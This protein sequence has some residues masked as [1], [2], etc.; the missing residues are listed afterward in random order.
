METG[1]GGSSRKLRA[2]ASKMGELE[3]QT[4]ASGRGKSVGWKELEPLF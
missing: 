4:G 3:G 1:G 2:A